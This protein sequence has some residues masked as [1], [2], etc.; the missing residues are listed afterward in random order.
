MSTKRTAMVIGIWISRAIA[1]RVSAPTAARGCRAAMSS[2]CGV[3]A[4]D[5]IECP[6]CHKSDAVKLW[7]L[8]TDQ[9][10]FVYW[11]DVAS[12]N[13]N[14]RDCAC[15]VYVCPSCGRVTLLD[16]GKVRGDE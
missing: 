3:F 14:D 13:P 9:S 5:A 6:Y 16:A 7:F 4:S 11:H 12:T 8:S 1:S 2:D 15:N 10:S